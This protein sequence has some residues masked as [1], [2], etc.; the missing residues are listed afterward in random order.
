[1]RKRRRERKEK[2]KRKKEEEKVINEREEEK[3]PENVEFS[4][5]VTEL[6][7]L[8]SALVLSCCLLE[9]TRDVFLHRL[10]QL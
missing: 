9:R 3:N 2:E 10:F 4:E 5:L 8:V 1:M 7:D 6:R